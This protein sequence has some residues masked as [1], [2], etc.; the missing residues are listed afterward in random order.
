[1][2]IPA[3]VM[4]L[5]EFASTIPSM[6]IWQDLSLSDD[7]KNQMYLLSDPKFTRLTLV[8][9]FLSSS[10]L[11]VANKYQIKSNLMKNTIAKLIKYKSLTAFV[12]SMLASSCCIVQILVNVFTTIGCIGIN[13]F[14]GK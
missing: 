8:T 10:L 4:K 3:P 7:D 13:S 9:L 6:N 5:K 1:M 2:R 11:F 12:S 14:L